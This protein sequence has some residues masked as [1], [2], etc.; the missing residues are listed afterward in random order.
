[1]FSRIHF[2]GTGCFEIRELS[3]QKRSADEDDSSDQQHEHAETPEYASRFDIRRYHSGA[4]HRDNETNEGADC[5]ESVESWSIYR[6]SLNG[7]QLS[8]IGVVS[9]GLFYDCLEK[10]RPKKGLRALG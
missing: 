8:G 2:L 9:S 1:M 5:E 4:C 6:F 7:D 3:K 10:C